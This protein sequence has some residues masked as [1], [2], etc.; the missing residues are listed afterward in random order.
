MPYVAPLGGFSVFWTSSAIEGSN[1]EDEPFASTTNSTDIVW[2]Y[3]AAAGTYIRVYNGKNPVRIEL[4]ARLLRHDNVKYLNNE[5]VRERPRACAHS[6]SG[7]LHYVL[8]RRERGDLLGI[9]VRARVAFQYRPPR[10]VSVRFKTAHHASASCPTSVFS[11]S[12]AVPHSPSSA[13]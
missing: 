9:T 7:G 12:T 5:R 2:V 4:G 3:G 11:P 6:W 13:S 1:N 10:T 8:C